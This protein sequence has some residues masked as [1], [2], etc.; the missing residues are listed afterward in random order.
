MAFC[1]RT[2]TPFSS[3]QFPS[4]YI[5]IFVTT[6]VCHFASAQGAPECCAT[7]SALWRST[8]NAFASHA[9]FWQRGVP[10]LILGALCCACAQRQT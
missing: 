2:P 3:L 1:R 8:R 10:V 6:Q 4:F 9:L 5:I 7:I